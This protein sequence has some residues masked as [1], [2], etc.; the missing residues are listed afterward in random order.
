MRRRQQGQPESRLAQAP[1]QVGILVEHEIARIE[2]AAGSLDRGTAQQHDGAREVAHGLGR[3]SAMQA[4]LP[5]Q[6]GAR[7]R[8]AGALR[9]RGQGSSEPPEG[10]FGHQGGQQETLT[11]VPVG[12]RSHGRQ[13][14]CGVESGCEAPHLG[15]VDPRIGV[16]QKDVRRRALRISEIAAA[17]KAQIALGHEEPDAIAIRQCGPQPVRLDDLR[18]VVDHPD[19]ARPAVQTARRGQR[20]AG[21]AKIDDDGVNRAGPGHERPRRQGFP[22]PPP[23]RPRAPPTIP[24]ASRVA[25]AGRHCATTRRESPL[26]PAMCAGS[27]R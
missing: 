20:F 1:A 10:L 24:A 25:E 22:H 5:A 12:C 7:Q 4:L 18:A 21:A 3:G 15:R 26:R 19:R 27:T 13:P 23:G 11:F 16:E 2:E 8:P 14:G 17:G 6:P 9:A